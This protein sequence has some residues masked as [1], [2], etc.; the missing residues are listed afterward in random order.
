MSACFCCIHLPSA[1]PIC[2]TFS[3]MCACVSYVPC[4]P[5]SLMSYTSIKD[6]AIVF[7][8]FV[9]VFRWSAICCLSPHGCRHTL[10]KHLHL[11][12]N[13]MQISHGLLV[14]PSAGG[15]DK[16]LLAPSL[17]SFHN[18][19]VMN[20]KLWTYLGKCFIRV[21]FHVEDFLP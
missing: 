16:V 18:A 12:S 20:R 13:G 21:S 2:P 15:H 7:P 3:N 1:V 9:D 10:S 11:P 5:C 6:N 8:K 17:Q 14:Q 19:I 4:N